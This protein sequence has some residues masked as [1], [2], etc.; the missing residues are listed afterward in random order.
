[1]RLNKV[2]Q[3]VL[4][5]NRVRLC[6]EVSYDFPYDGHMNEVFYLDY[7]D[8]VKEFLVDSG[9]PWLVLFLPICAVLG[10][11]LVIDNPID[12]VLL[13]GC[14][15]VLEIW[16]AWMPHLNIVTI[17]ASNISKAI[18]GERKTASFFS[19]G[20][21]SM[22]TLLR[23]E[24]SPLS[25]RA[26]Y[27]DDLISINGIFTPKKPLTEKDESW[28]M[29]CRIDAFADRLDKKAIHVHTN[30]WETHFRYTNSLNHSHVCLLAA[31]A[32]GIGKRYSRVLVPSSLTYDKMVPESSN[33]LTDRLWSTDKTKFIPDG[34]SFNRFQK[35]S[36]LVNQNHDLSFLQ[37]CSRDEALKNCSVCFKCVKTMLILE[38]LG[39]LDR[40][41]LFRNPTLDLKQVESI[42]CCTNYLLAEVEMIKSTAEDNGRQD[43]LLAIENMFLR[44]AWIDSARRLIKK[45]SMG[46]PI[47]SVEVG[48]V[49]EILGV[50]SS[51][52][53]VENVRC[54]IDG[55]LNENVPFKNH[56]LEFL[57]PFSLSRGY[58]SEGGESGFLM[59]EHLLLSSSICHS[60]LHIELRD[61]QRELSWPEVIYIHGKPLYIGSK[62]MIEQ[63]SIAGTTGGPTSF[64]V[65]KK[66]RALGHVDNFKSDKSLPPLPIEQ[67]KKYSSD[68]SDYLCAPESADRYKVALKQI[69]QY[70]NNK[71]IKLIDLGC[72]N[73]AL[74][75]YITDDFQYEGF[76]HNVAAVNAAQKKKYGC[77][78]KP[79]FNLVDILGLVGNIDHSLKAD[80]LMFGDLLGGA[81]SSRSNGLASTPSQDKKFIFDCVQDHLVNS[82]LVSIVTPFYYDFYDSESFFQFAARRRSVLNESLPLHYL[83]PLT[84]SML[85]LPSVSDAVLR[86]KNKPLWYVNAK[87]NNHQDK[88]GMGVWCS[89]YRKA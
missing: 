87:N 81:L 21:D 4:V 3:T 53:C 75:N 6:A 58:L 22:H 13:E 44:S 86:Q 48:M 55:F 9:D 51:P 11:D 83:Q 7:P 69:R 85:P 23:H 79:V 80:V 27:V 63:L 74:A 10:E 30:V 47:S 16:Q 15:E 39:C 40:C 89:L 18:S 56:L 73:G 14:L 36:Y 1:M 24:D 34:S 26:E 37:V 45:M 46:I 67:E 5:N 25:Q 59:L 68:Y 71:T 33:P 19:G 2:Y 52:F 66:N 12:P 65:S 41:E 17:K 82:G 20:V 57:T 88:Q 62:V 50:R 28:S 35:I 60:S 61:K 76:D 54:A 84:E 78:V 38:V 64:L 72:G 43:V 70:S 31:S 29:K 49:E 32:L 8:S 77:L 42:Y